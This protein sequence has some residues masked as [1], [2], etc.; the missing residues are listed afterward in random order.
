MATI[1]EL[2]DKYVALLASIYETKYNASNTTA[3]FAKQL[4]ADNLIAELGPG[5]DI[6]LAVGRQLDIIGKYVGAPRDI[7]IADARPYFGFV[8]YDYPAGTQ[9]E[10]GFVTYASLSTNAQ[11][12]W[13]E[14]EFTNQSTTELPDYSYRQLMRLKIATNNTTNTMSAIQ[15]QIAEFFPGQLQLRDNLDMSLTYYFGSSF[16]LPIGVLE[17]YLPRPMGVKVSAVEAIAFDV[18]LDGIPAFNSE[19]PNP[20]IDFG[21]MQ[22]SD[23]KV[24]EITNAKTSTF[25]IIAITV[26]N[27]AFSVGAPTPSLPAALAGGDSLSFPLS[28]TS[29]D[30]AVLVGILSIFITSD[31]GLSQ[32]DI[33]LSAVV[34]GVVI[35]WIAFDNLEAYDDGEI[36]S[37]NQSWGW[38]L[39]GFFTVFTFS[40]GQD[41]FE[42]YTDGDLD[43]PSL[44]KFWSAAGST[45]VVT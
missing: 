40:M 35:S 6:E 31:A 13:Y 36:S 1:R 27:P 14:Y 42:E 15:D 34:E 5:F 45:A 24:V 21:F 43:S 29:S 44:G 32:F 16:Q 10:N 9:N 30:P 18:T 37:L 7:Q 8:T 12:V 4:L 26:D 41:N 17:A 39:N 38:A 20:E 33:D 28:V 23:S 11:G 2:A 19:T 3:L 22:F 25:T